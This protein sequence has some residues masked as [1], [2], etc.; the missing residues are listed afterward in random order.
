MI[1]VKESDV[2][3][4]T[5]QSNQ[6]IQEQ[7]KGKGKKEKLPVTHLA[8]SDGGFVLFSVLTPQALVAHCLSL[9]ILHVAN[10]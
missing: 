2:G 3:R 4:G 9:T 7:G 6:R 8:S 5:S 10:H 1:L